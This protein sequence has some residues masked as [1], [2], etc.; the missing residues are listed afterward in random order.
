M[1]ERKSTQTNKI[2]KAAVNAKYC[3]NWNTCQHRRC[4]CKNDDCPFSAFQP[5]RGGK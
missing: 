1:N 5:I 4:L 3:A 2:D